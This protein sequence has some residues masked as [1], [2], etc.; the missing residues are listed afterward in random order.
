MLVYTIVPM[1][2][3]SSH[4]QEFIIELREKNYRV[5]SSSSLPIKGSYVQNTK[6]KATYKN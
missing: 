1:V 4:F 3:K 5:Y 2:V 6:V